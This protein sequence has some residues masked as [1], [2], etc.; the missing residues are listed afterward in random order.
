MGSGSVVQKVKIVTVIK[1]NSG[2]GNIARFS[3]EVALFQHMEN[4]CEQFIPV[5]LFYPLYAF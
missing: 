5:F 3:S 1:N 4:S 2:D